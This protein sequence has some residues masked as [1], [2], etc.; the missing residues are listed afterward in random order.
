MFSAFRQRLT[1]PTRSVLAWRAWLR[2]LAVLPALALLWLAVAWA[3]LD[4]APW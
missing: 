3:Q 4:A 1:R 2:V